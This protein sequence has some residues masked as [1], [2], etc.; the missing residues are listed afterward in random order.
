MFEGFGNVE[1]T[2]HCSEG[3]GSFHTSF[4]LKAFAEDLYSAFISSGFEVVDRPYVDHALGGFRATYMR[5]Y[6]LHQPLAHYEG[7]Y[8]TIVHVVGL[9]FGQQG[10]KMVVLSSPRNMNNEII[11][12]TIK[13][14]LHFDRDNQPYVVHGERQKQ[15]QQSPTTRASYETCRHSDEEVDGSKECKANINQSNLLDMQRQQISVDQLKGGKDPF[16][17]QSGN[18]I[19]VNTFMFDLMKYVSH[20][21]EVISPGLIELPNEMK[22]EILKKLSVDS[23]IKMSQ[24]NSE[25]RSLIFKKCGESLW[26]HLCYRDFKIKTIN[27]SINK[28]WLE[29]YRDTYILYQYEICRKERALPN[30]PERPALPAAPYR[31]QIEWLPE[32]LQLPFYPLPEVG[33]QVAVEPNANLHMQHM[34]ALEFPI[35]RADSLDSLR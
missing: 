4:Q 29:L 18:R 6:T 9:P 12:D 3:A 31:L 14:R 1:T 15:H 11:A 33:G 25:F 10:Q 19:L 30:V 7:L 26:R 23:I 5:H 13:L 22:L 27:R 20:I 32:A 2:E 16:D 21:I 24:V 28:T 17:G 35:R 8:T 34:L